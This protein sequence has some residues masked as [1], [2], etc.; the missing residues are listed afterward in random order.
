MGEATPINAPNALNFSTTILWKTPIL[1]PDNSPSMPFANA[2]AAAWLMAARPKTLAA[3]AA[4][5]VLGSALA[6]ADGRFAAL[7]ALAAL[8]CALLMQIAS[9]LINDLYDFRKG[10][11]T[12]SRLG[13]PRAVAS[14]LISEQAVVRAAWIVCGTAFVL[15][16][17]LVWVGGWEILMIGVIS[18]V[19]AWAYTGGTMSLAYLGLGEVCAFVFFGV[20]PVCGTY[21]VQAH[22]WSCEALLVA[23]VPAALSANILM[24]NNIRDIPS[25]SVAGKRTMPVRLG[26]RT[27][28]A[29]YVLLTALALAM[30]LVLWLVGNSVWLLLG[31]LALPQAVRACR[32]LYASDGAEL[33]AVLLQTVQ[34]L[35][36]S[37][38]LIASGMVLSRLIL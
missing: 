13:P 5:V 16:Q 7:P 36:L 31:L 25:D 10:A 32:A 24:T 26:A 22:V 34:L 19:A 17:Y 1:D 35:V 14:G 2:S 4:P 11:D 38:G 8:V 37:C 27:A 18:L 21:F 3:G 6:F 20:I 29:L 15:G 23:L 12:A 30:P 33:N 28:R 9:N